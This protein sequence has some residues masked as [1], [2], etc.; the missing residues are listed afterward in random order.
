VI[1]HQRCHCTNTGRCLRWEL[2]PTQHAAT[3]MMIHLRKIMFDSGSGR[4]DKQ[5][6]RRSQ[7]NSC[8]EPGHS[9]DCAL[10]RCL[11][12]RHQ[13]RSPHASQPVGLFTSI[14]FSGLLLSIVPETWFHLCLASIFMLRHVFY[15]KFE[16]SVALVRRLF[17]LVR[18]RKKNP[19]TL[20][21]PLLA[22]HWVPGRVR[23]SC[24]EEVHH[25]GPQGV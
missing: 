17:K 8:C 4:S 24:R 1:A 12:S 7:S 13:Q 14:F 10:R 9:S 25:R 6:R 18:A 3:Y 20:S 5:R 21:Q 15:L 22:S 16:A 23:L 11:I 2:A 19:V